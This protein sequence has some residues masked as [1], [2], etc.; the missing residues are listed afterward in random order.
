M[1][2]RKYAQT[3]IQVQDI[4]DTDIIINDADLDIQERMKKFAQNLKTIAP[5]ASDFLYFTAVMMHAAEASLIDDNGEIKKHADGSPVT[6]HWEEVPGGGIKW[7]CS[8]PNIRPY[9]NNN[10]DIFPESELKIAYK[11]WVGRPLCLDHK[12]SSVDMIR[13]VIVDTYWDDSRKRIIALCALDKKNHPDLAHK[14]SSGYATNV[15]MGTAVGRAVCTE[16]GCH[17]VARLE[18]EFCEHMRRKSCYGEINLDLS[19]IE[20]SLVVTGA[21]PKAKVKHIIAKDLSDTRDAVAALQ[22]YL[23]GKIALATADDADIESIK[24]ELQ[25]LTDKCSE[26]SEKLK[27]IESK[28]DK[29]EVNYGVTESSV[30]MQEVNTDMKQPY[31]A[32][33]SW[34]S[35]ASDLQKMVLD[36]QIKLASIDDSLGKLSLKLHSSEEPT[37]TDKKAYLNGTE[38]PTPGQKQYPVDPG[39]GTARMQD[40]HMV[41]Q[42][43]FPGV[44]PVDGMHPGPQ[45]AGET[46]EQRKKRLQRLADQERRNEIRRKALEEAKKQLESRAYY[47]GTEEPN[48]G[49]KQYPVDPIEGQARQQDKQMVGKL[50]FPEVGPVDGLYPEDLKTKQMLSRAK[51][52]ARF[53]KVSSPNGTVDKAA[54]RWDIYAGDKLILSASVNDITHGNAD[55]LFDAVATKDFG[56]S[57]LDKIAK[58]GFDKTKASLLKSAQ[59]VVPA[60]PGMPA[61]EPA[62]VDSGGLAPAG[63][64]PLDDMPDHLGDD[65][66]D[67]SE[68]EESLKDKINDTLAKLQ[69]LVSQLDEGGKNTELEADELKD[70]S[71]VPEEEFGTA[72]ASLNGMR[73]TVNGLLNSGIKDTVASLN[74]HI[75]ELKVAKEV[76]NTKFAGFNSKQRKYFADLVETA[77][78][79]AEKT[80]GDSVNLMKA[81]VNYA[82]GTDNII[83]MAQELPSEHPEPVDQVSKPE[84]ILPGSWPVGDIGD[85]SGTAKN[86]LETLDPNSPDVSFAKDKDEDKDDKKEDK[87]EDKKDKKDD[88]DKSDKKEDKKEDKKG[89]KNDATVEFTSDTPLSKI[90]EMGGKVKVEANFNL[91]T[92]EGRAMYRAKLA[93][94]GLGFSDMLN[95][96]HP[97]GG[98][99]PGN[100]DTNPTGD[101]GKVE[102]IDET[103][104]AVLDLANLPPRVRKQAQDIA[105]LVNSGQLSE[106]DVDGLISHGID[107]DAVKYYKQYWGEAK[108]PAASEFAA[109]LVQE[110]IKAKAA[111]ELEEKEVRIKRAYDLAYEMCSVGMIDKSQIRKQVEQIMK[112]NDE[113]FNSVKN[114]VAKQAVS[115][116]VK[117]ASIPQVGLL[118]SEDIMLPSASQAGSN[119]SVGDLVAALEKR[120]S[121]KVL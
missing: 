120:W 41:G 26:L 82:Y 94:Q 115:G 85:F 114:I 22:N 10:N 37:M 66:G 31:S 67:P 104:K 35:Y 78:D 70:V 107:A 110:Q 60:G 117:T 65:V 12:S 40:K 54:S 61:N 44:G 76:C 84:D 23:D 17:R 86:R 7:V 32:P 45:S 89:D 90:E 34:P 119:S 113:G 74:A 79:D 55:I 100:L 112:W 14:V 53:R 101:L 21:D 16:H 63:G 88:D 108:D 80:A 13:G 69:D 72:T 33:E 111:A 25:K 105:K 47:N 42:S 18:S 4:K 59:G 96:A 27:E 103:H 52:N 36:T 99:T 2:F 8:D 95:K 77:V 116:H 57:V 91:N 5:R 58:E 15:S 64:G 118:H 43:P 28:E 87:K 11:K 81:F 73:K 98:H 6:A 102:R 121:K 92:K 75:N 49:Q 3:S 106:S 29:N 46:E 97:Q 30:D 56:R 83:S 93:Q 48:P 9:K 38:E 19:P 1:V 71:A 51:L 39:E 20:L 50:P 24:E 109:K 68:M 62:G